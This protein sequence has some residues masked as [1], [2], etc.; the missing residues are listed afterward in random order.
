MQE[1]GQQLEVQTVAVSK[2]RDRLLALAEQRRAGLRCVE[3]EMLEERVRLDARAKT[4]R[5]KQ[6]GLIEEQYKYGCLCCLRLAFCK[7]A[8][9]SHC[10]SMICSRSVT[11][12]GT[13]SKNIQN[14]TIEKCIRVIK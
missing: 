10:P 11:A 4:E 6:I 12:S 9:K 1:R 8:R 13:N 7:C 3:Q 2:E 14:G 5:L